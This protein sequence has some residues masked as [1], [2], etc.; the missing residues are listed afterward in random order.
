MGNVL[1]ISVKKDVKSEQVTE[2][3]ALN[4]FVRMKKD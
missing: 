3:F 1:I 4:I 2:A